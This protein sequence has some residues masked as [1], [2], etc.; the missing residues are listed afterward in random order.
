MRR[1]LA[2]LILSV[3]AA[4]PQENKKPVVSV[5]GTV[6]LKG[7][8][9]SR[10]KIRMDG[11]PKCAAL[12]KGEPMLTEEV[13]V[14]AANHLQWAFVYVKSGLDSVK[15]PDPPKTPVVMDQKGCHYEPHVMGVM[16]GQDFL[17][18]C[19]D[20]LL[21]IPHAVP[22]F[23]REWG[24]SQEGKGKE[25][26]KVFTGPEIMVPIKCDVH[27]WMKAWV[28][29]LDHPWYGVTDAAGHFEIKDLPPGKY[30]LEVW[31]EAYKA[32]TKEIEVKEKAVTTADVEVTDPK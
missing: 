27:V 28:G 12:H 26:T 5:K 2:V 22:S 21:H 31:H 32:A 25:R 10:K 11:D 15:K 6:T 20:E 24:F 23:N 7:K 8:A 18:R 9:P 3:V 19:S 30:T 17:V 13:L 29:V 1:V 16:V 14:D 4:S